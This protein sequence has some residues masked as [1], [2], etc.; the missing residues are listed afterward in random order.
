MRLTL[1]RT[2]KLHGATLGELSEDGVHICYTL[3]D[4]V[5]PAGVKVPGQTAIPAGS[6]R[7]IVNLS[8]RFRRPLPLVQ[9][10]P[11]FSGIRI[12]PGNTTADTEGCILVG[13]E[14]AGAML[15]HSRVAFEALFSMIRAAL[16]DGESVTLDV[17]D[18]W[19]T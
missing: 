13:Y 6:Y 7:V 9:N 5:R 19:R 11:G 1:A 15:L 4:T 2:D 8:A 14:R 17:I 3:E 16:A 10:V 12:H 18:A